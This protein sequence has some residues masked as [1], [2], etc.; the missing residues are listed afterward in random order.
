MRISC[1]IFHVS[2]IKGLFLYFPKHV[3][4]IGFKLIQLPQVENSKSITALNMTDSQQLLL[5]NWHCIGTVSTEK[6]C[7]AKA[8]CSEIVVS[9]ISF[10]MRSLL[11]VTLRRCICHLQFLNH[12]SFQES[13]VNQ[14]MLRKFINSGSTFSTGIS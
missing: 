1:M 6:L 8:T 7:F 11:M 12:E 4:Q 13:K 14:E 5:K 2:N 10:C 3:F 9:V